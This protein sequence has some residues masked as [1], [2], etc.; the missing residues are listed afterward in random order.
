MSRTTSQAHCQ[1][2]TQAYE[3]DHFLIPANTA[4]TS[5]VSAQTVRRRLQEHRLKARK[6]ASKPRLTQEHKEAR[7]KWA[8]EHH[9]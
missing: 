1:E 8:V 3:D 6:P 9:R 2:I 7:M 4:S 5:N